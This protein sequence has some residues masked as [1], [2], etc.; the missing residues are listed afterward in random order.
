[1]L[2]NLEINRH[3][4]VIMGL[5]LCSGD[6]YDGTILVALLN[7]NDTPILKR[8]TEIQENIGLALIKVG[9]EVLKEKLHIKCLL[10]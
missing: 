9:K 3:L 2:A 8:W 1:M 10:S 7:L 4:V 5:S 6:I